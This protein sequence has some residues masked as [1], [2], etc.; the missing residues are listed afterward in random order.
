MK[1]LS[2]A[3]EVLREFNT[4]NTIIMVSSYPVV[5]DK[6]VTNIAGVSNYTYN[7]IQGLEKLHQ[8]DT[9]FII[10]T[11]KVPGSEIKISKN[12][13]ILPTWTK[14]DFLLF[15]KIKERIYEFDK[16]SD[17]LIQFEFNLFGDMFQTAFF[18]IFLI[19]IS[20]KNVSVVL[21]QVAEN[22]SSLQGHLGITSTFKLKTLD[23]LYSIFYKVL[24]I[25][26]IKIIVHDTIFKQR[27]LSFG[28]K[29]KIKII[30]HGLGEFSDTISSKDARIKLSYKKD[31]FILLCFGFVT[32]YKGID[33]IINRIQFFLRDY[34]NS[35]LKLVIA[36]GPSY[37]LKDKSHYKKYYNEL[38]ETIKPYPQIQ[39]TGF[40]ENS[41]IPY[42]FSASDLVMFPY[43]TQMSAS[44]PFATCLSFHKPFLLSEPLIHTLNTPDIKQKMAQLGLTKDDLTF[45]LT[46]Y[47][48]FKKVSLLQENP[49]KIL[50][51]TKLAKL[52]AH[53]R[54]WSNVSKMY[55]DVVRN[56]KP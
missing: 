36:G 26:K 12:F 31:D 46:G 13:L 48:I 27:L 5:K 17:I 7:L 18:P 55:I 41:E 28:C 34:P 20:N 37:N 30:P 15:K 4:P 6:K 42:Y 43:R 32:W 38:I 22:I 25:P 50:K 45:K 19:S 39:I 1:K 16:V 40:V 54:D 49:Q 44:G 8:K 35:N 10:I 23:T 53:I 21:H 3:P 47:D 56:T 52:V 14:N 11:D 29:R 51:I 24:S 33:L 9:K 2:L